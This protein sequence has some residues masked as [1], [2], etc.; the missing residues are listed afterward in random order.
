MPGDWRKAIR[1]NIRLCRK[2]G[3]ALLW[4][5]AEATLFFV[6]PDVWITRVALRSARRAVVASFCAGVGAVLG[7]LLMY[8]W[9]RLDPQGAARILDMVPAIS[10]NMVQKVLDQVN[11]VGL[12]AMFVGAFTGKPYKIYAVS[13]GTARLPVL[14]F[15]VVSFPARILRFVLLGLAVRGLSRLA[16]PRLNLRTRTLMH[17]LGWSVFYLWYWWVME[18]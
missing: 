6:V 2:D 8:V 12:E 13:A 11:T 14:L 18:W 15:T 9:G 5:F 1:H 16:E 4:G 10:E 3:L 17:A 7:G